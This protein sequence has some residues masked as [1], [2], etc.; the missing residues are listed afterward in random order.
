MRTLVVCVDRD[1]DLGLK[2]DVKGPIVGRDDN[3]DAATRLALADPEDSDL[4]TVFAG[5]KILDELH[6]DGKD[7][8]LVTITGCREVGVRSDQLI[9]D[10]LDA[11]LEEYP[12]DRAIVVTDGAEDEFIVPI[13]QSRLRVDAVRRVVVKQAQNLESTY[14]IIKQLLDDNEVMRTF[15]IPIGLA[16]LIYAIMLFINYPQGAVILIAASIGLYALFRGT[17]LDDAFEGLVVTMKR[18]LYGAKVAFITYIVGI[19]LSLVATVNGF[20]V[21][22]GA[23]VREPIWPGYIIM[24]MLFI[25]SSVWWYVSSVLVAVSGHI[26]DSYLEGVKF[27]RSWVFPFFAV[28]TG[29][30]LWG[31]STYILTINEYFDIAQDTGLQYLLFSVGAAVIVS[32]IGIYISSHRKRGL[33]A[34]V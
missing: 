24:S 17:G 5:V 29:L 13:V 23:F 3:V 2:A 22:W 21:C 11:V 15:F 1:D 8:E 26:V 18:S 33:D 12:A 27:G 20:I 14:Y 34:R 6:A 28:A 10:Q 9:S 16:L 25:N 31:A 30:V 4:N 19:I 7:A 32:L